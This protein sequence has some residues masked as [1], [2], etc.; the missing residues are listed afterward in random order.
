MTTAVPIALTR[1]ATGATNAA[2]VR[3]VHIGLGAF[4]RA[5]QAWYTAKADDAWGIAAF[6]GR[7]PQAALELEAQDGLFTL[8]TRG[9]AGDSFEI[10]DSIVAAHDGVNIAALADYVARA[11]VG[12]ITLTITEAGYKTAPGISPA[13]LNLDDPAVQSDLAALRSAFV[14]DGQGGTFDLASLSASPVSTTPAR[15]VVALADRRAAGV[16]PIAI[17][18]C[19][20]LPANG[21]AARAGIVGLAQAVSPELAGWITESV[22]FVDSSIDRITPRTTDAD[23]AAVAAAT[24]FSDQS[25][26]VTEPFTSWVL[27]GEFP[28]GRPAWEQGGAEFVTSLDPFERRKLWL[29]NGAHSL[30]AYAGQLRGHQTVAQAL[31][32]PMMRSWVEE[33]WDAAAHH[34]TE[35]GLNVPAYRDQLIERFSNPNIAHFLSQIANDGS[36]KLGARA[37]P[38]YHAEKAAGRDGKAALRL[39][40]AWCDQLVAQVAAGTAITDPSADALG[41]IL[42]APETAPSTVDQTRALVAVVDS[43]LALDSLVVAAIHSLRGHFT[44]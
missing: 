6:T 31:A 15:L 34:L 18:S 14:A 10:I 1:A 5:H 19:D 12:V 28:A 4:H 25:P 22:S 21:L 35:K 37:V 20:N 3:I 17:V 43:Q 2:P 13:T 33:F 30:M 11:E 27:Q 8:I 36:L 26:V 24:G 32:D 23:R 38:V 40:A 42:A 16:G 29:L 39:L 9:A 44:N 41:A 7:S